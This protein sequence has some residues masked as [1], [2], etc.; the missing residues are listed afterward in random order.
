MR[1]H[2]YIALCLGFVLASVLFV[3]GVATIVYPDWPASGSRPAIVLFA[4]RTLFFL[5]SAALALAALWRVVR[6]MASSRVA[7]WIAALAALACAAFFV[8]GLASGDAQGFVRIFGGLSLLSNLV[9][10]FW[11]ALFGVAV[12]LR[13]RDWRVVPVLLRIVSFFF[14]FCILAALVHDWFIRAPF[15]A[16][17]RCGTSGD[18]PR[19]F[20]L[21]R[22]WS[23]WYDGFDVRLYARDNADGRWEA[24]LFDYW[25]WPVENCTVEFCDDGSPQI[26]PFPEAGFMFFG[27]RPVAGAPDAPWKVPSGELFYP[28]DFTPADLHA[29][30]RTLCRSRP[31]GFRTDSPPEPVPANSASAPPELILLGAGDAVRPDPGAPFAHGKFVAPVDA[32]ALLETTA[33]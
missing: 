1:R 11:T 6:D 29:A 7:K 26:N 30:H 5:V 10:A 17:V 9:W 12:F 21:S 18:P 33:D 20:V 3:G 22:A 23:G 15:G 27:Q 19:E 32:F 25:P 24:Y 31:S 28:A 2:P 13:R 4:W 14:V 8:H 16:A